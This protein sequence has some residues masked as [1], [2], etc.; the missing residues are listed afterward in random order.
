VGGIRLYSASI[1]AQGVEGGLGIFLW[2]EQARRHFDFQIIQHLHLRSF[3]MASNNALNRIRDLCLDEERSESE[4]IL[5]LESLLRTNSDVLNDNQIL[6][7]LAAKRRSVEFVKLLVETNGNL[8]KRTIRNG[9]LPVHMACGHCNMEV[10]KY[11][12][13][14]YP[15]SISMAADRFYP[16]HLVIISERT[17]NEF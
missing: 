1:L 9:R 12:L 3:T 15:E 13:S 6:L 2:R 4:L 5:Q 16:L 8:V 10:A 11:L 14:I 7:L 17:D